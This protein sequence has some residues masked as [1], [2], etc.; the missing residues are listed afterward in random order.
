[1]F[2]G[3]RKRKSARTVEVDDF[4]SGTTIKSK[5][6]PVKKHKFFRIL[7][8]FTA[9][10][11]I[12]VVIGLI[13]STIPIAALSASTVV[14]TP[15]AETWKN[16]SEEVLE[17]VVIAE[18]NTMYDSNG[19]V[20]AEVW[21]QD[22]VA[23]NSLDDI[24]DYAKKALIATEDRRF[25]QNSGFDIQSTV[26][27]LL[28]GTGGGSGI[29]QQLVKNL[30][31]YN[32]AG[33]D[34][35]AAV[36]QSL[37]RKVKEL[38]LAINYEKKHSK[39][40]ILLSYFNTVAFGSPNIYSIQAASQYFFGKDAKDLNLAE[41]SALIGSVNNPVIYNLDDD[42]AKDSW[43][44]R[45]KIVLDSMVS[46]GDISQAEADEAFAEDLDFTRVKQTSGNCVSSKYP[47]YCD[48][49]L[50]Y[51]KSSPRLGETQ[52]ERDAILEKGGLE[53]QTY[54][55]P[56]AMEIIDKRLES[57]FGNTNRAVAP[58]AIVQPG[59]GGV[60]A[61]GQNRDYGEGEGKTTID[62]ANRAT[63]TGSTY[64]PITLAAALE[65]GF[66]EKNLTFGSQC[67]LA[68]AG[69]DFPGT[70]FTNSAGCGFQARVLT[71]KEA[72]A[73]SS[74]TWY[75]TLATKVGLSKVIDLSKQFDLSTDGISNKS[76][77]FVLGVTENT[78]VEMAAVY[79]TFTNE[80][81]F[82]PSTP[83]A[84]YKYSDGTSPALPDSYDPSQD[85]C[86]RV[87]SPHT[88][89]VVLKSFK[90]NT[91]PGEVTDAFGTEGYIQNYDAVGKTGTNE[92]YNYSWGQVS[93]DYSL[94][95]DI[96]DMDQ[97][98]RGVYESTFYRGSIYPRNPAPSS[99]SG[100]LSE[101]VSAN[102]LENRSLDY[103]ST[104]RSKTPVPV[105]T[106]DYFTVP[107]VLGM[108]PAE[109]VQTMKS[110]GIQVH[111]SKERKEADSGYASNVIVEQS[112]K[113]GMQLP[114]GT[115]KE[116]ILYASR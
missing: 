100:I 28:T 98:T 111:L 2:K 13:L 56:K 80:G 25:Y 1:M 104:D 43:K 36:E 69:F 91:V 83:V 93:R 99:G 26:R 15:I 22:R 66:D 81:I 58:T 114:I 19:K 35:N 57:D 70:G 37:D 49:V 101:I 110:L 75:V 61:F 65:N 7:G 72:T 92:V 78:P 53:I 106:R 89:S 52:E 31:F 30:L 82:C 42:S 9:F 3:Y 97:P 11:A 23:L 46:T 44:A 105:E 29:T 73:W 14:I 107:S 62:L 102:H 51:L 86:R 59:T 5:P 54:L 4:F 77:A 115:K 17:D 16:A 90:A 21:S 63:G 103:N 64:K 88:A 67:P 74:N 47:A 95:M 87:I 68:P 84:K 6:V 113:P 48:Y 76:L 39:D 45:Q 112:L 71:Y 38:K 40:E 18:R 27:A 85:A 116:V 20:F 55:D 24:S 10:L 50:S 96:Y 109:A 60:V 34:K 12:P 32:M 41:A 8:N 94:F 79:A 108:E 33:T